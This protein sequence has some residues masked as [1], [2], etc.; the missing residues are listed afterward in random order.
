MIEAVIAVQDNVLKLQDTVLNLQRIVL[1]QG[2]ELAALRKQVEKKAID[3]IMSKLEAA[4]KA[5]AEK[6]KEN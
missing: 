5:G 6:A 2:D 4:M 1:I 3:I